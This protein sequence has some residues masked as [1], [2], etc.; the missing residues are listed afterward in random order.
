M[1]LK[2]DPINPDERIKFLSKKLSI[3]ELQLIH[4]LG[5]KIKFNHANHFEIKDMANKARDL[6]NSEFAK[7]N[8]AFLEKYY[9]LWFVFSAYYHLYSFRGT[10]IYSGVSDLTDGYINAFSVG[11]MAEELQQLA[12]HGMID[13]SETF[14]Y[15]LQVQKIIFSHKNSGPNMQRAI[16]QLYKKVKTFDQSITAYKQISAQNNSVGEKKFHKLVKEKITE[17]MKHATELSQFASIYHKKMSLNIYEDIN[18]DILK[19]WDST[20]LSKLENAVTL[21]QFKD[22]YENSYVKCESKYIALKKICEILESGK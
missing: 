10:M 19:M 18:N 16:D 4:E 1:E 8:S 21:D 12:Y 15:S 7:P 3:P 17:E 6:Y 14:E 5:Y 22:V 13:L 9:S 20:A 2:I 11:C